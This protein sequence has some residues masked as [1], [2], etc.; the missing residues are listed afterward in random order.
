M[1]TRQCNLKRSK[2]DEYIEMLKEKAREIN[3]SDY[4]FFGIKEIIIFGSYVNSD[5][6]VLGDLD[7]GVALY[8][9]SWAKKYSRKELNHIGYKRKHKKE[10]ICKSYKDYDNFRRGHLF[11]EIEAK[12]HLKSHRNAIST[13]NITI[14][15]EKFV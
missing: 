15:T 12:R 14:E 13:H 1:G 8:K 4:F 10:Y 5:K 11:L 2:A 9:K 7:V 3:A 6:E